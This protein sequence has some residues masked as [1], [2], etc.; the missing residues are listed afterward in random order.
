MT[1]ST[2]GTNDTDAPLPNPKERRRLREAKSLSEAQV[3]EVMGVTQATVRSWEKGRT[4]PR[5]RRRESY[6]R[7][8]ATIEAEMAAVAASSKTGA[9]GDK[10]GAAH[11][12]GGPGSKVR[13]ASRRAGQSAR[14]PNATATNAAP[15]PSGNPGAGHQNPPHPA[16][17][18][19]AHANGKPGAGQQDPAPK[20]DNSS[21][22]RPDPA[23]RSDHPGTKKQDTT[24]DPTPETD[25][26]GARQHDTAPLPPKSGDGQPDTAHQTG[27][28][29]NTPQDTAHQPPNTGNTPQDTTPPPP[30]TGDGQ[31]DTAHQT[32]NTGNTPQ[33]TDPQP[34]AN[35]EGR[36]PTARPAE[37]P[38]DH[39]PDAPR[40]TGPARAQPGSGPAKPPAKP[41]AANTRPKPAAKRAA[42]P[43][44]TPHARHDHP[45]PA[46]AA[47][48]PEPAKALQ[49]AALTGAL[50]G[51]GALVLP[52]RPEHGEEEPDAEA[53]EP[54][55]DTPPRARSPLTSMEAVPEASDALTPAEAFDALYMATAPAL[56]RQAYLLTG[57]TR[58]SRESVE[59]AFHLAWEHWPEVATDRDPVGWVR[60]AAYEYAMAPWH[61]FRLARKGPDHPPA[62]PE[63]RALLDA[64]LEL[65]P[66]YRR[67][68][69]LYDG[70]GLDLPD[71]A[72]ETEASTPAAAYRLLHAR[73]A[74][75]RRVPE[76]AGAK[77]PQV[78]SAVLRDRIAD[79][80]LAEPLSVTK[81][82]SASVV[83]IGGERRRRFWTRAAIAF[84]TLIVGA[85]AFTVVTVPH[86][87][88]RPVPV[89]ERVG[90]VPVLSGPQRLS[91]EDLELRDHLRQAPAHGPERLVLEI[92]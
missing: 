47:S 19:A 22:S 39:H 67:T 16:A 80:A 56:A 33:V 63:H 43:P 31:P 14:K 25:T 83:R 52:E 74:I 86:H 51:G 64:L 15:S 90:G 11:S 48:V 10:H 61:R 69:L 12:A 77:D 58:L 76:V 54:H 65:P 45:A 5:G 7:L 34:D 46:P 26:P 66:A 78:L 55:G 59:R 9:D 24:Q 8:L 81:L 84:T 6:S 50:P 62:E 28:T 29:G 1:Q 89:G 2:A 3:A 87:H 27:N 38:G 32:G 36:P 71:T 70:L 40:S 41:H 23:P 17:T 92:R 75:A 21:T 72:A 13:G 60:A 88:V 44:A 49:A 4:T 30:N 20:A 79:L 35:G 37:E 73:A 68:V 57:R 91:P 85:T 18:N 42:K 53:V 82:P